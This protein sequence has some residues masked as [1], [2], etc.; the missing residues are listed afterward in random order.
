MKILVVYY[1]NS[2]TMEKV[3][4][5]VAK[6]TGASIE[7]I[8]IPGGK[9][10]FIRAGYEATFGKCAKINAVKSKIEDYDIVI[11]GTPIWAGKTSSPVNAFLAGFGGKIKNYAVIIT[12]ADKENDFASVTGIF[13]AKLKKEPLAFLSMQ[14][15]IVKEGDFSAAREFVK[16]INE[17]SGNTNSK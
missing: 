15:Q 4:E 14:M 9:K 7:A 16:I 11:I 10:G 1:S 12:R 3:A 17:L 2:G 6:E 5:F 13:S 8:T